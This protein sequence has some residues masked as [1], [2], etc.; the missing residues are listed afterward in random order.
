MDQ[1]TIKFQEK[2][3][4]RHPINSDRFG[5]VLATLSELPKPVRAGGPSEGYSLPCPAIVLISEHIDTSQPSSTLTRALMLGPAQV[6]C[7]VWIKS[8]PP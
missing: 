1:Y 8:F 2:V 4:G 7:D 6:F 5:V 3:N